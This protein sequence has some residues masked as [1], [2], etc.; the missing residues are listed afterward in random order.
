MSEGDR[1][2]V[3]VLVAPKQDQRTVSLGGGG[4]AVLSALTWATLT[5][6]ASPG[7]SAGSSDPS[8]S[9]RSDPNL[10]QDINLE[11]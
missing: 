8:F 6:L 2:E 5:A 10:D 11:Y 4:F 7:G 3:T 1:D 9:L